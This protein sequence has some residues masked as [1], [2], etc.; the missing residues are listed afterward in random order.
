MT[1]DKQ[2][3]ANARNAQHSTGPRTSEG[4]QR[5]RLNA[6]TY[7]LCA[8]GLPILPG[9]S[10]DHF[11]ELGEDLYEHYQPAPGLEEQLVDQIHLLFWRQRRVYPTETGIIATYIEQAHQQDEKTARLESRMSVPKS[12]PKSNPTV[13]PEFGDPDDELMADLA[14]ARGDAVMELG[15]AFITDAAGADALTKLARYDTA[16]SRRLERLQRQL[17]DLQSARLAKVE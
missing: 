10:H 15:R 4:K 16:I 6:L 1:S 9:E 7:G 14:E 5:S 13:D 8:T 3:A 12:T 11:A 17:H 2:A